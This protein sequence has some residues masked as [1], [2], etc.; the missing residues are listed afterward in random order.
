MFRPGIVVGGVIRAYCC[1]VG[2]TVT[3]AVAVAVAV[4]LC[5]KFH[6]SCVCC[7]HKFILKNKLQNNIASQSN[8]TA[9]TFSYLYLDASFQF[10]H[11]TFSG[12]FILTLSAL[13][14]AIP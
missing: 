3:V 14:H 5:F 12:C 13:F 8:E 11:V 7:Q 4:V 1:V 10:K 9:E 2:A 6:S